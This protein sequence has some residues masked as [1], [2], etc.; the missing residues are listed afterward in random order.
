MGKLKSSEAIA[1]TISNAGWPFEPEPPGWQQHA[2]GGALV[3]VDVVVGMD[4]VADPED[5]PLPLFAPASA[6]SSSSPQRS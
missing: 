1:A 2:P 3:D 6:K 5:P 4:I